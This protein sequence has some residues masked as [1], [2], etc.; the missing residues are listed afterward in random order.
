MANDLD[1]IKG[2][3]VAVQALT[4]KNTNNII[5]LKNIN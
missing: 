5:E 3:I 2:A 4:A 1:E